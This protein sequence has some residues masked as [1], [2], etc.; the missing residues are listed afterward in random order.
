MSF[1]RNPSFWNKKALDLRV[2][3]LYIGYGCICCKIKYMI[4][5]GNKVKKED[6]ASNFLSVYPY[7][8]FIIIIAQLPDK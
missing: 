3:D 8:F 1:E 4:E 5:E 7:L 2:N 6:K